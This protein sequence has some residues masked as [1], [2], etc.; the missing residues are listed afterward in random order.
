MEGELEVLK[1]LHRRTF[2]EAELLD[3]Y[4]RYQNSYRIL[5]HL[6]QQPRFPE[7][8][9]LNI[10]SQLIPTD[11]I[12]VVKNKHTRPGIRKRTELEFVNKCNKFPL[13]E[14]LSYLKIAPHSLLDYFCEEKDK[15][16]LEVILKNP[17]CTE[18]LVL[19]FVNRRSS[20]FPFYDALYETE[21][22]KRPQVALAIS[23]DLQAPIRILLAII[24]FLNF[25]QLRHLFQDDHTHEV[26]KNNILH[27]LQNRNP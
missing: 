20:R 25:Q 18:E 11:L 21:W 7:Q 5:L 4:Y 26:V 22:Y 13:G 12:K 14:K 10:I 19:K 9:A 6:V 8:H 23:H 27:Y 3:I 2:S 24:P 15:R 17:Y 16:V 1:Q